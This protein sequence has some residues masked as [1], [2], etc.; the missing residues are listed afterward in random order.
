M[1]MQQ[2]LHQ[3]GFTEEQADEIIRRAVELEQQEA[4]AGPGISSAALVS[5]AEAA[6]VRAEFVQRAI[7]EMRARQ[8]TATRAQPHRRPLILAAALAFAVALL[9]TVL[10]SYRAAPVVAPF[11]SRAPATATVEP[12]PVEVPPPPLRAVPR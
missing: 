8:A 6:G 9:L 3:D 11:R 12:A 10:L 1:E 4:A 5:S 7:N 2:Q